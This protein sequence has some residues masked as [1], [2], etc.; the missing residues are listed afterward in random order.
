MARTDKKRQT[1]IAAERERMAE[2]L[3]TYHRNADELRREEEKKDGKP[4]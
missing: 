3:V 4:G 2:W 1:E